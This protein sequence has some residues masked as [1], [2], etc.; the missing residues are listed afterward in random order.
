M[1]KHQARRGL[2]NVPT[3][4]APVTTRSLSHS[5]KLPLKPMRLMT[6][7]SSNF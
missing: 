7:K 5:V 3:A 6:I 1:G 4:I 2:I